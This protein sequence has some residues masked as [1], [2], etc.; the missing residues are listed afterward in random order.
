MKNQTTIITRS[1]LALGLT[2]LSAFGVVT[3]DPPTRTFSKDG[4]GGSILTAGSGIWSAT[5]NVPWL[6]LTPR[7]T[8]TAGQ[9]CIYVVSS[10]F[11]ADTR[12]AIITL[13]GNTHTVTQTG[14]TASITPPT[15]NFTLSGGSGN[16]N[17]N[18]DAGVSWTAVSNAAWLTVNSSSGVSNGTVNYSVAAYSG[19]ITR[20]GTM[21][22]AGKTFTA[23]QTGA[24]VNI[25]PYETA[26]AYSSDIVQVQVTALSTTSW[27]VNPQSPWISVVDPGNGFGDSTITLAIGT[28][29]S[30]AERVGTVTIGSILFT[31][32][33]AGVSNSLLA[34]NPPSA[35]ANPLGAVGNI[36]VSATPNA[37]WTAETLD[38]WIV[39]ASGATGSG[40]GNVQYVAS[41]NPTFSTRSGR[42][43]FTPPAPAFPTVD[44]SRGLVAVFDGIYNYARDDNN[45]TGNTSYP[46]F[47]GTVSASLSN[48]PAARDVD[49]FAFSFVF[50]H[51][52]AGALH[53][54]FDYQFEGKDLA[55]WIDTSG[56]P[57]LRANGTTTTA[58]FTVNANT[59]YQV[60]IQGNATK[61]ELW[62][63]PEGAVPAN[64]AAITL[65]QPCLGRNNF[66]NLRFGRSDF[67]S[68]GFFTG[69]LRLVAM[70]C[71]MLN[72]TEI[73]SYSFVSPGLK[74]TPAQ[75]NAGFEQGLVR[76]KAEGTVEAFEI[77]SPG[78][79]K[80]KTGGGNAYNYDA[81]FYSAPR[82]LVTQYTTFATL[83]STDVQSGSGDFSFV[84]HHGGNLSPTSVSFATGATG[85]TIKQAT[86]SSTPRYNLALPGF[87][88]N[89]GYGHSTLFTDTFNIENNALNSSLV[90]P[91]SYFQPSSARNV[92]ARHAFDFSGSS[93]DLTLNTVVK[94]TATKLTTD[95]WGRTSS[96]C[97]WSASDTL[98]VVPFDYIRTA[99]VWIYSNSLGTSNSLLKVDGSSS[100]SAWQ[101]RTGLDIMTLSAEENGKLKL[102]NGTASFE[103][104][105]CITAQTWHEIGWVRLDTGNVRIYCDGIEVGETTAFISTMGNPEWHPIYFRIPG[106]DGKVDD[107]AL[108]N[109]ALTT[110]ELVSLH[111]QQKVT[112]VIH[113]VNQSVILGSLSPAIASVP[114]G[115]GSSGTQMTIANNVNWTATTANSWITILSP[116]SGAD[117][118]Q[119]QVEAAANPTV[120]S[121]QGIV[122][123]AGLDFT[124][125]QPGRTSSVSSTVATVGTDGGSGFIDVVTEAGA[126]WFATSNVSWLTVALGGVGTGNGYVLFVADPYTQTSLSRTG[127]ITIA[128]QTIYITQRGYNLTVSPLVS[129]IGSNATEGE[130]G[131]TAP[132]SAIWEVFV[133]EPWI[134]LLG[135]TTGI[136]NGTLRYSVTTNNTGAVRTGRIIVSGTQ[137]SITQNSA[138]TDTDSDGL[139]DTWELQYFGSINGG[140]AAGDN[141]LDGLTNLQE[142]QI[143]TNPLNSDTNGDGVKDGAAVALASLGF[144]PIQNSQNLLSLVQSQRTGLGL[145]M[146]SE[147]TGALQSGRNE[148]IGNPNSYDLY[149]T[150]QMRGLALGRPVIQRNSTTGK[151]VL[152]LGVKKSTTLN[153]WLP[154]PITSSN[155]SVNSNNIQM[156]FTSSDGAAFFRVEGNN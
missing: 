32:R 67:P 21:T 58:A 123:I 145:A 153:Q 73:A 65:S 80:F 111:N 139:P 29:P 106:Y 84:W 24:D 117:S 108:Y 71:R 11:S 40:N 103:T 155:I 53:R 129:Q 92:T 66:Q 87:S 91:K 76:W 148:V 64:R 99:S 52:N 121:R 118:V 133:T 143:S 74:S 105:P 140:A 15:A 144:S 69:N 51:A 93:L 128:G 125:N 104:I 8:G 62:I 131:I 88:L 22:I 68:S 98:E 112:T 75:E 33:Q 96:A 136:G 134:T 116:T 2:T 149:R 17:I 107:F 142:Y 45:L 9:S 61:A 19:V 126:S 79:V 63:A 6:T 89:H 50:R 7:T 31:I 70:H 120:Y 150:D 122:T 43:R 20:S 39:I 60:I 109:E 57:V 23:S 59:S 54:L 34:I 42:I 137:Y 48:S 26:K 141:D 77:N 154:L 47:N 5:A 94:A 28:N 124:L 41:A 132:L 156:E 82:K 56:Q 135:G 1:L 151:F 30:Y 127:T 18:A 113:T 37:P 115:G 49:D 102:S 10:N 38:P 81:S 44:I 55:L 36:A 138:P 114:V 97:L 101:T 83:A 110:P 4:G 119:L 146:A 16:I 14:Y 147:L 90:T 130:F 100:A 25:S 13:D 95:R 46:V 27:S 78:V 3:I 152:S 12:Q 72:A 86:L 35:E 85:S